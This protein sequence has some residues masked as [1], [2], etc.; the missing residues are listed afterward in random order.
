[1]TSF[2]ITWG[3]AN[4]T[5]AFFQRAARSSG[6]VSPVNMANC[7]PVSCSPGTRRNFS[8][9]RRCCSTKGFVG[10]I[11]STLPPSLYNRDAAASSAMAVFPRPVGS[12]TR[13]WPST[14]CMAMVSW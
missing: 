14:A 12:T 13:V 4:I 9:K 3:V 10:A 6:G 8:K 2:L 5:R 11:I 7:P 1:M